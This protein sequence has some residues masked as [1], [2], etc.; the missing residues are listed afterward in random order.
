[1]KPLILIGG[2]GHCKSVV[3]VAESAGYT[4]LGIFDRPEEVGKKVL[5]YEIIGTDDDIVKYVDQAEFTVTVGQIKSPDL[6][7]K[8]YKMIEQAEGTLATKVT[9]TA[10]VSKHAQLDA[11]TVVMHQT[12]INVDGKIRKGFI[13]TDA[14]LN[15]CASI[16]DGVFLDSQSVINQCVKMERGG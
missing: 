10:H 9:P 16:A 4:I 5:D 11:E 1:M 14:I 6:H 12:V 7:I 15:G 8:L 2:G 13:T 3:D